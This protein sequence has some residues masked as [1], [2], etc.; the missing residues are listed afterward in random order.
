MR[1]QILNRL[2][3][4]LE[5]NQVAGQRNEKQLR[6]VSMLYLV[7][8]AHLQGVGYG[9]LMVLAL[10]FLEGAAEGYKRGQRSSPL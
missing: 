10:K 1:L 6:P 7:S 3:G 2:I 8:R 9:L 4:A 5:R